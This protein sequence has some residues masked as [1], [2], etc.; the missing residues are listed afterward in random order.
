MDVT[1][2]HPPAGWPGELLLEGRTPFRLPVLESQRR[3][4]LERGPGDK[5]ERAVFH[6]PAMAASRTRSVLL[7]AHELESGWLTD[8]DSTVR[9][10]DGM[11]AS[12]LRSRRWLWELP[13][14]LAARLQ[15]TAVDLDS[16]SISW[17]EANQE[18]LPPPHAVPAPRYS[19]GDLCHI[20]RGSEWQWLDIDPFGSP[21]RFLSPVIQAAA[22]RAVLEVSATDTAALTG[23]SRSALKRRYKARARPDALAHDTGLRILLATIARNAAQHGRT[24]EPLLSIWDGH[25]LR[26]S[27]RIAHSPDAADTL[28]GQLGWRM[29]EPGDGQPAILLP[30]DE[31]VDEDDSRLSGPLWIGPLGQA[32]AMAALTPERALEL[33]APGMGDPFVV[34]LGLSERDVRLRARA[35]ERAVRHIAGEASAIHS[36]TLLV[37]DELPRLLDINAPPSPTKLAAALREA[38]HAAAVAAYGEPAIRTDAPWDVLKETCAGF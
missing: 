19:M 16:E 15:V 8:D 13:P 5:D 29:A 32:E 34:E 31:Q 14:K 10:L 20:A 33:C 6:N 35:A 4:S 21:L 38:G 28:E 37:V 36:P 18:H 25:H 24:I 3:H 1:E 17:T 22:P 11:A 30:L 23:S 2:A 12:G 27:T 26:I 7:L 9:A